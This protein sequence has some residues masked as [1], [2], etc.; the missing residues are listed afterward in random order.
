M[1]HNLICYIVNE[2]FGSD[3]EKLCECLLLNK[4]F[5]LEDIMRETNFSYQ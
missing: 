4:K 3:F 5:R 2:V 1:N